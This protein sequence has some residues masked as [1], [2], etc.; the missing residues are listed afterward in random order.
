[1][2]RINDDGNVKIETR[3]EVTNDEAFP[4]TINFHWLI[5][6]GKKYL[7]MGIPKTLQEN[8]KVY[9]KMLVVEMRL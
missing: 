7:Y 6:L 2:W 1:M 9:L 5:C 8:F 4:T 3:K